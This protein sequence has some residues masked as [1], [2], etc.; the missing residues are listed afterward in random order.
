MVFIDGPFAR[1]RVSAGAFVGLLDT[2]PGATRAYSLR[3]LR[4]AYAGSAVRVRRSNDDA[5]ADIGFDVNG[6]FDTAALSSHVSSNSGYIATWYDQSGNAINIIMATA[7]FQARI[8]NAG[9]IETNNSLPVINF[10]LTFSKY[11]NTADT[12]V[13]ETLVVVSNRSVGSFS[14]Y[15]GITSGAVDDSNDIGLFA[16]TGA[17]AWGASQFGELGV[18]DIDDTGTGTSAPFSDALYQMSS[19]Y[20]ADATKTWTSIQVGDQASN[21]RLWTGDIGEVVI[22]DAALDAGERQSAHDDQSAYWGTP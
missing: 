1:S 12:L 20:A 13:G 5:E 10:G 4:S 22:Y 8:V 2:V 3:K 6:D 18:H 9:T 14:G 15:Q 16:H 21:N 11:T 19:R 17:S 7:A